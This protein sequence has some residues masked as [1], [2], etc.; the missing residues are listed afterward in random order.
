MI[1]CA[2]ANHI[3]NNNNDNYHQ[4]NPLVTIHHSASCRQ[5]INMITKIIPSNQ[6]RVKNQAIESGVN[7]NNCHCH[8]FL[9]QSPGHFALPTYMKNKW[10]RL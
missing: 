7:K 1:H 10:E 9:D 5:H 3:S 2:K 4:H 8:R 6:H